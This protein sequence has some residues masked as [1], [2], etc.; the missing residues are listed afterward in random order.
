MKLRDAYVKSIWVPTARL[1][2]L[3]FLSLYSLE[4]AQVVMGYWKENI[5][6]NYT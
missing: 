5:F 4:G 2:E 6:G 1:T 3:I